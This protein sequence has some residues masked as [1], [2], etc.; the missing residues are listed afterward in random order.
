[1]ITTSWITKG[2]KED[3]GSYHY[4][5]NV[6][7]SGVY[8]PQVDDKDTISFSNPV[9]KTFKFLPEKVN[10]ANIST[11]TV[12]LKKGLLLLFP[13]YVEHKQGVHHSD[14]PRYSIAFNF[15]PT[16]KFGNADST[17]II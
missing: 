9:K 6:A 4:H 13:S 15:F 17:V 2:Y 11:I 1:M 7:F 10:D 8:Y 12:C 3:F 16:G 14:T 5:S